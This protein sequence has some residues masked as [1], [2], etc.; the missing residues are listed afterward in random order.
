MATFKLKDHIYLINT[1]HWERRLFDEL[2][3]L[4]EGTTYN[5]YVIIG[6][7]KTALIDSADTLKAFE[8]LKDLEALGIDKIDYVI[9]NHAEQDHSGAIPKVLNKFEKAKVITNP[10]CAEL[11]KTHLR[12]PDNK[13]QIIQENDLLD[14]G[15]KTLRFVMTPWVHWPETQVTFLEEDHIAFTCD[16]FGSHLATTEFITDG[17]PDVYNSAKRYYAEI[18]A[19]FRNMISKNIEKVENFEPLMICPSHGPIYRKPEFII[20]AYKDWIS[21]KV[22]NLVLL[23]YVSMHHSIEHA[24]R[25]LEQKLIDNGVMVKTVSLSTADTGEVAMALIDA[26]TIIVATPTVHASAHPLAIY[27]TF[28]ANLLRPKTKFLG[29]I[30]S[31]G[32][33][34]KAIEDLKNLFP[35]FKGELFEP[36][37][38]KGMPDEE[39]MGKLERLASTIAQKHKE[40]GLL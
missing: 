28:L 12:I 34:G 17:T 9:A 31:Y 5:A 40:V 15:G 20:N 24:I 13:F 33:G 35:N 25:F 26:A 29:I 18:M 11:L 38:F 7:D 16:F 22:D 36:I 6:K 14:L 27:Y 32:W 1:L 2:I 3:P 37:S 4:P 21:D 23:L 8:F 19:P 10:K 39:A 30:N